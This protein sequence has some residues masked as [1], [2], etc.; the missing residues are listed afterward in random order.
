[1]INWLGNLGDNAIFLGVGFGVLLYLA[2]LALGRWFKRELKVGFGGVFQL[3]A[4]LAAVVFT[5]W[6]LN[7]TKEFKDWAQWVQTLTN[8]LIAL[9]VL[10]SVTI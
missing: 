6:L 5:V 9:L 7:G 10:T 2:L 3:F 8:G 1:M 4:L